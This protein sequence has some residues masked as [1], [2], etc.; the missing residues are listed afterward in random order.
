MKRWL[1]YG[2]IGIIIGILI[3]IIIYSID[4]CPV[5][6][7]CNVGPVIKTQTTAIL[8]IIGGVI[9]TIIGLIVDKLKGKKKR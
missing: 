8:G 6:M 3:G 2:L 1:K 4:T 7:T 9:G 5:G